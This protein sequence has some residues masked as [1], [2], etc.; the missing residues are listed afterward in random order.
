MGERIL[1][2]SWR[3]PPFVA[4]SATI[5]SNLAKQFSREE[6]VLAGEEPYR[7]PAFIWKEE[8]PRIVHLIR[9]WPK[10]WKGER[11]WRKFSFPMLIFRCLRLARSF[12]CNAVVAVFP[13]EEYLFAGYVTAVC[14]GAK[15]YPYFHN[16]YLENRRGLSRH[17]AR[18]LQARVFARAA[19][20]FVMSEAMVELYQERYQGVKSSALVHSLSEKIPDSPPAYE[21]RPTP[22][23]II[24]GQIYEICLDA[25]RRLCEA[26]AQIQDA[27]LTLL[28]GQSSPVLRKL[29]LLRNG[30]RHET[31]SPGEVV[32]RLQKADFVVLPHGFTG[33]LSD[34]EY[35][36]TFPT[37]TIEY[38]VCGR[39]ILAHSPRS[40]YLT[41]FLK[42]HECALVVDEQSIPALVKAIERLRTDAKLRSELIRNALR[43]AA[44]FDAPYVAQTLRAQLQ[45][46]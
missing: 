42:E 37:R 29:G 13:K 2:L 40:S 26:I 38:L 36:T 1:L 33:A 12:K 10:S 11:F 24:S 17:F 39:P 45:E 27:S 23:F 35:R 3:L 18:W 4:G 6:M 22:E 41:R 44:M 46:G 43:T 19:H 21:A 7:D 5:V 9:G 20:V 15:F 25:T 30:A 14:T 31:V 16:P 28:T 34:E 8:W 32:S